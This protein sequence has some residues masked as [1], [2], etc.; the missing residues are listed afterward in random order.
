V[1]SLAEGEE[2]KK[3]S[4]REE[5]GV[6]WYVPSFSWKVDIAVE[7]KSYILILKFKMKTK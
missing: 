7:L 6:Y 2:R 3:W 1:R 5:G 4:E